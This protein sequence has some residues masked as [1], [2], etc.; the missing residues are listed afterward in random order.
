MASILNKEILNRA[1]GIVF[2]Q[3]SKEIMDEVEIMQ[4]VMTDLIKEKLDYTWYK[5]T[6]N[7]GKL[8]VETAYYVKESQSD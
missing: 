8:K 3:K 2:S 7:F 5:V 6:N 4:E 1:Q